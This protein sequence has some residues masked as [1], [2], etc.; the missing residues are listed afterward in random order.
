ML[1]TVQTI[2]LE[3]ITPT[4]AAAT[5]GGD[6]FLN[7]GRTVLHIKNGDT[8]EKTV[9]INSAKACNFGYDHDVSVTLGPNSSV[10]IGPFDT[11]R[12]ND[13]NNRVTVLY[14]AVTSL[15]VAAVTL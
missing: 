15:T 4:F 14:D 13:A 2:S 7:N 8:V 11:S 3:G 9:V 12:F 6:E 1:L 5:D 10:Q